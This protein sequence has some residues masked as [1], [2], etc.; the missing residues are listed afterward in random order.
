MRNI[1][2]AILFLYGLTL[3]AQQVRDFKKKNE[4]NATERTEM[5]DLLREEVLK[6]IDQEVVF[7]VNHFKVSGNYAWMEGI[8][9]GRGGASLEISEDACCYDCCHLESLYQ[10]KNG[11]WEIARSRVFATDVWYLDLPGFFPDV[12]M[13]IFSEAVLDVYELSGY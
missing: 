2:G 5:L 6:E 13:Q 4:N 12:P 9:I 7:V 1:L 8:A 10:K 11:R 3:N